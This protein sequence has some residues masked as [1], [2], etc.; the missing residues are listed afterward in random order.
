MIADARKH[1]FERILVWKLDRFARSRYD[2]AIYKRELRQQGVRVM[3][4][5]EN[6][7]EGDE[8]IIMEAVL[9]A[10]AEYYSLDLKRKILRGQRETIAKKLF[11]GGAVP[12]GYKL[13]D[14]H[15]IIDEAT[16]PT[17]RY[18]FESYASG[19]PMKQIIDELNN[20]GIRTRLG[21]KVTY[22]TF[23]RS[24]TN[25]VYIG[26][27]RYGEQT[28]EGIA[29]RMISDELFNK[30]QVRVKATAKAPAA[31][32]AKVDYIL[33]GKCFCGHCG[34]PMSGESGKGKCGGRYYYYACSSRKHHHACN[35]K[36]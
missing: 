12:Y 29:D 1:Q 21:K 25:T 15:L 3:S 27:M 35:K 18:V 28:V 9:E 14:R 22:S 33:T 7:G 31:N 30:V 23:T 11:P 2:S 13:S 26:K 24:L 19:V 6:V 36:A 20:R 5:T 4:V 32:K 34:S 10:Y 17:I 16:A 8:S